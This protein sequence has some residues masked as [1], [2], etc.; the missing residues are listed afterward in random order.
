[1]KE[2]I[3]DTVR[4]SRALAAAGLT[5]MVWGHAAVRD[6]DSNGVWMKAAGWGFEEIS[7][8]RVLLVSRAGDVLRGEG[9]RHIEYP[10]HTEIIARRPDV[11]CVVHT[12]A[13]A[14]S[15]FASLDVPLRPISHDGVVFCEPQ[16]P[17]FTV[18]GALIATQELGAA[19]AETLGD[20]PACLM[21]Q[22]GAV[23]AGP[24]AATAVMYAVLLERACRT[25]LMAMAAGGP[26]VWSD[27]EEASFK[28]EQ[29]WNPAQ[30]GAGWNYLGRLADRTFS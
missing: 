6:P 18:T 8:E 19:L 2:E 24:D 21:P 17:R 16:L 30:L 3:D 10:I 1:M 15:A 28:R 14:L 26:K 11:G 23:T 25:Q 22:H 4:A 29:I 27:A 13:P 12:H 9:K 7:A 5:D 20:A